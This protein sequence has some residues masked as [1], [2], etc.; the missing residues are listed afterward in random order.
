MNSRSNENLSN[1]EAKKATRKASKGQPSATDEVSSNFLITPANGAQA[2][3]PLAERG[4]AYW[5][6]GPPRLGPPVM[7]SS[8]TA[9]V[10]TR[11]VA[12][13]V[14]VAQ[15]GQWEVGDRSRTSVAAGRENS[16]QAPAR[17]ATAGVHRHWPAGAKPGNANQSANGDHPK[18]SH[19]DRPPNGTSGSSPFRAHPARQRWARPHPPS[20]WSQQAVVS[21]RPGLQVWLPP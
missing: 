4:A 8:R 6:P 3:H 18:N 16:E 2:D 9:R 7:A 19:D 11:S 12:V 17:Q 5:S 21:D 15:P 10:K 1:E 20:R 13:A 14:R